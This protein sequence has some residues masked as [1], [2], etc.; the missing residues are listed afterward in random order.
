M[1]APR[2]TCSAGDCDRI[3]EARDLCSMHYTRWRRTGQPE[4]LRGPRSL[5]PC[6]THSAYQRHVRR[7]EPIDNAC[8][9]A[10]RLYQAAFRAS[11][12]ALQEKERRETAAR[13]RALWRLAG[14]HRARF[15][16]LIRDE[17]AKAEQGGERP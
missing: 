15:N 2:E 5:T 10:H 17:I 13:S 7:G 11:N 8:R 3:S 6:G 1:N 12:P 9:E 4:P 16:E 14:E